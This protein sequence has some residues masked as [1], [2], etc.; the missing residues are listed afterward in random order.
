MDWLLQVFCS[1]PPSLSIIKTQGQRLYTECRKCGKES[2]GIITG[3]MAP[4]S[5]AP[6]NPF[7]QVEDRDPVG[8]SYAEARALAVWSDQI[9]RS[10]AGLPV[11]FDA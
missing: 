5:V 2:P 3:E 10:R 6:I 8:L 1:H 4:T 11:V 9:R 7:Y